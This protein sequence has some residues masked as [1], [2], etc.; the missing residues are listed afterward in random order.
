MSVSR[1]DS[2]KLPR[3]WFFDPVKH[4]PRPRERL[5]ETCWR[6]ISFKSKNFSRFYLFPLSYQATWISQ[7]LNEWT[8]ISQDPFYKQIDILSSSTLD[9][10]FLKSITICPIFH[11]TLFVCSVTPK[12]PWTWISF[13]SS[14]IQQSF[15]RHAHVTIPRLRQTE[16]VKHAGQDSQVFICLV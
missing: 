12:S 3:F 2:L 15:L 5:V 7:N 13:F 9:L 16:H 8:R 11:A 1:E 10:S 6:P 4:S 14:L